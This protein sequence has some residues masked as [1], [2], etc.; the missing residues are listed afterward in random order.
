MVRAHGMVLPASALA[1]AKSVAAN[2]KTAGAGR[3]SAR[4]VYEP[5]TGIA[6]VQRVGASPRVSARKR[7]FAAKR[8]AQNGAHG[9]F[10]TRT[11]LLGFARSLHDLLRGARPPADDFEKYIIHEAGGVGAAAGIDP[12]SRLVISGPA[13]T[14]LHRWYV[15]FARHMSAEMWSALFTAD[16]SRLGAIDVFKMLHDK[17]PEK[18]GLL[19]LMMNGMSAQQQEVRA[20]RRAAPRRAGSGAA[21]AT[22]LPQKCA[23]FGTNM[24][25]KRR[26][27]AAA[28]VA[29]G[30]PAVA[31][32]TADE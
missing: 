20:R 15:E 16:H 31:A 11:G 1:V 2:G 32:A 24:S 10:I 8:H 7:Y 4:V 19:Q 29:S 6:R 22:A 9:Y 23:K 25:R 28:V 12:H 21:H 5:A 30:G 14:Q 27:G 18:R 26:G 3:I 13:L 17:C